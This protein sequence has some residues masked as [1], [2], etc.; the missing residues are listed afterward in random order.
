MQF[1]FPAALRFCRRIV[2]QNDDIYN[3][4][5]IVGRLFK[6]IVQAFL[7]NGK[8]YN[9]LNSAILELFQFIRNVRCWKV[10]LFLFLFWRLSTLLTTRKERCFKLHI[11][12]ILDREKKDK[13]SLTLPTT[14]GVPP[15]SDFLSVYFNRWSYEADFLWLFLKFYTGN[16][17]GKNFFIGQKIWPH[18]LVCRW[19]PTDSGLLEIWKVKKIGN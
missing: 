16:V 11:T 6:P 19:P 14:G 8:R 13:E 12:Y 17:G 10:F 9:L 1:H 5:I 3:K 2:N 18:R 7:I 4:Y 15:L